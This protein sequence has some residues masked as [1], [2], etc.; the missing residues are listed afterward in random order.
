MNVITHS[1]P[2]AVAE[3]A[4]NLVAAEIDGGVGNVGLAG[5]NTPRATYER[6]AGLAVDWSDTTLWLGDERWVPEDHPDSNAG[7]ARA[8]FVDHVGASL[9]PLDHAIGDPVLAA[10]AYDRALQHAFGG[11]GPGLVLLGLGDDGHT[12]S[13]FP[14]TAALQSRRA[15]YVATWVETKNVWRLTA[16]LPLLWQARH[17]VFLV[18]GSAK[19]AVLAQIA[20]DHPYPAQQVASGAS[21]VTWLIDEAAASRLTSR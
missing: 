15:G 9:L 11:R 7:M 19:A 6:L 20:A 2:S 10:R 1:D 17:I 4:A 21:N 12:A 16:T 3:A 13:L 14:G 18:T 5:G 8:A